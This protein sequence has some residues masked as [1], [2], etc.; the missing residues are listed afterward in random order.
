MLPGGVQA[1]SLRTVILRSPRGMRPHTAALRV[2][3]MFFPL[4]LI[5]HTA[6]CQGA[7]AACHG[8]DGAGHEDTHAAIR[9]AHFVCRGLDALQIRS[10]A[11]PGRDENWLTGRRLESVDPHEPNRARAARALVDYVIAKRRAA[12]AAAQQA[13]L[14]TTTSATSRGAAAPQGTAGGEVQQQ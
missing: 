11:A 3:L 8:A 12:R 6:V 9:H 14:I 2:D 4:F 1:E 10:H 7:A 13:A 5:V